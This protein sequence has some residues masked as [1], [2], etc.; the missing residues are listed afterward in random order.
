M[1]DRLKVERELKRREVDKTLLGGKRRIRY[2]YEIRLENLLPVQAALTLHDQIPVARHEEIKVR[3]E[4]AD[5]KP[6]RQ[7]EL[8]LLDWE[9]SLAPREKRTLRFD[10]SVEYPQAMEVTGLP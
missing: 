1:D 7:S 8:N 5:P 6:T 10:F 9:L 4:A 3:L 2:A